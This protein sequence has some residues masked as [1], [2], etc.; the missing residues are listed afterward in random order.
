[1]RLLH[2]VL[3]GILIFAPSRAA[4]LRQEVEEIKP[5][6]DIPKSENIIKLI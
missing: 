3:P 4:N 1:M 2:T 5:L 6:I